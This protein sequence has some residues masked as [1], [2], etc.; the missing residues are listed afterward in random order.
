MRRSCLQIFHPFGGVESLCAHGFWEKEDKR[1][2]RVIKKPLEK[3]RDSSQL[4]PG[5]SD[6]GLRRRKARMRLCGQPPTWML[7]V[8]GDPV[9][10]ILNA[11]TRAPKGLGWGRGLNR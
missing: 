9:T 11:T 3:I 1:A 8:L 7:R 2:M 10:P 6:S 5:G 4:D